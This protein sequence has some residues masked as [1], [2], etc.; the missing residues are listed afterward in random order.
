MKVFIVESPLQL[1]CAYEAI[2]REKGEEYELLIRQTGR[3]L[4]D[5]HLISCAEYLDLKYQIFW[6]FPNKIKWGLF[7]NIPLWLK[8]WRGNYQE[9]YLGSIYSSAL[10]MISKLIRTKK[11]QYLDDGA[12]TVRAQAEMIAGKREIKNWFT[13]FN[14]KPLKGQVIT[15]HRFDFLNKLVSDKDYDGSYFIGQPVEIMK[16]INKDEY[17]RVI[18]K[19][20]ESHSE[21]K[22]LIYIPHRVEDCEF[23]ECYKN[24]KILRLDLPIELYFIKYNDKLPMEVYSFYS[25]ALVSLKS[26]FPEISASAIKISTE[27]SNYHQLDDVY[28]YLID[29]EV[30]VIDFL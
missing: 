10:S 3:G 24:I 1:L 29:N 20:A 4:N 15:K 30:R 12:A 27:K 11:I 5:K 16:G 7:R 18:K 9:A 25:T 17:I 28:E 22:P 19:I 6:L 13:F 2:C 8:L 21:E 14:L 23:L 26:L